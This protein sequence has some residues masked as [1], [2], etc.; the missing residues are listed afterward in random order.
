MQSIAQLG[1]LS[2]AFVLAWLAPSGPAAAPLQP[3]SLEVVLA[4]AHESVTR[5]ISEAALLLADEQ[6]D[7]RAFESV[8]DNGGVGGLLVQPRGHRRWQAE[9]ALVP[10]PELASSGYPW[11]EFRDV[12]AVD[13]RPVPDRQER[14]SA[15]FQGQRSLP[16]EQARAIAEQ[17]AR[18][19]LGRARNINTPSMPLL[20]LHVAN[21]SRFAFAAAG[22][23][24]ISGTDVLKVTFR[25]QR[26]PSLIK[27]GTADCTASG[28][29]WIA[30]DAGNVLQAQVR[31]GDAFQ[32]TAPIIVRYARDARLGVWVPTEMSERP[33]D[34]TA[35]I[36]VNWVEGKCRYSNYRRF[37]TGAKLILPPKR[38]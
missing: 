33:D 12:L 6:C 16:I 5:Y 20:I 7:Q 11:A 14:L 25:E 35:G 18:F 36:G 24:R 29:M 30:P 1:R 22:T 2:L 13:G 4:R 19:N 15:L 23:D 8:R 3:P 26:F 27:A 34:G 17:G 21:E 9:I 37:E 10:T 28:T 31:C 38:P 32:S